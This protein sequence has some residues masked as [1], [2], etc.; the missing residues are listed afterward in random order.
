MAEKE[1]VSVLNGI[2]WTMLS[3]FGTLFI[4]FITNIFLARQLS[5]DDFGII[6]LLAIFVALASM[7]LDGGLGTALIQ[8]K[9]P[10]KKDYSTV[11]VFNIVI[12]T[13]LYFALYSLAPII[14]NYYNKDILTDV[15][16]V[17]GLVLFVNAFRIVQYNILIKRFQFKLLTYV[18]ITSALAGSIFGVVL[19][20]LGFGVWSLVFNNLLYSLLFTVTINVLATWRPSFYF[21]YSSFKSLFS[22]GGLILLSNAIDTIYKNIQNLIIGKAFNASELGYYTQAKKIEEVPVQG[23]SSA[24]NS[25]LFPLYSKYQDSKSLL[26]D[27]LNKNVDI[28]TFLLFPIMAIAIIVAEPLIEILYT[29]KWSDSIPFFQLLCVA[30]A[31]LPVNMANLNIIKSQGRGKLYLFMQAFQ[32][33]IGVSAM[34]IGVQWGVSGLICGC[35]ITSYFYTFVVIAISARI[36]EVSPMQQLTIIFKNMLIAAVVAVITFVLFDNV[37]INAFGMLVIPA[38]VYL[39]IYGLMT[40]T[41]RMSGFNA[42]LQII[43]EK[44]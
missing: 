22:F 28:L 18:D 16:R 12:S 29:L 8:K 43:R 10:E 38:M 13:L 35:I 2:A 37:E 36:L 27:N 26:S 17:Q 40:F 32:L 42:C 7:I 21:D 23:V 11:F 20:Y 24:I 30:G 34:F 5:Q 1:N 33:I 31:I 39:L 41:F 4:T 44:L 9:H 25:V 6:G 15:L 3:R 19:A 14:A